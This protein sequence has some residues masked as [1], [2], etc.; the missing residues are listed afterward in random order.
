MSET[1]QPWAGTPLNRRQFL[2]R[3]LAAGSALAMPCIIPA[4]ALGRGGAVA[5]SERIVMGAIG[6]G[7][8]GSNDLAFL[9]GEADVQFVAVCDVQQARREGARNMVNGRY[10]NQ[11][12]VA[13]RDMR[14]LLSAR[15]DIDAMLIATGD[16]WHTP[17]AILAMQA[18]KDVYCEK[19]GALTIAQG[20]ALVAAEKRYG[21]I[22]QTGAQRASE[23]NFI[24]AGE[25]LRQ[26]RLGKIHTVYAHLGYLPDW[27]R[28][29]AVLPAQPEPP[30]EQFDWDLW[31]GPSPWRPYHPAFVN[32]WP[33]PGWYTQ[34][35]FAGGIPQ[36]G[37]HTILQ[38]QLDLG[39]ADTSPVAYEYP[40]DLKG[41]GM[42]VHFANGIKL[43]ARCGGWRGSCGV[44]YEG[45]EG[46]VATADGYGRPEVSSPQLLSDYQKLVQDY[47][48]RTQRPLNHLRNFLNCVR[49]R[50]T[51]VTSAVVAHRTMTTNLLMDICLDL[52][53]DLKWDPVREE[54][55]G[56][57]E[58]N[59]LRSRALRSPWLVG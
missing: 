52:K 30:K 40:A 50:R 32:N 27:P 39:L 55:V 46:W 4:A 47:T 9:L 54:F 19:P 17:A 18:G 36:W 20:Q 25:L 2:K 24:V 6:V 49:T 58:A 53:R 15:T 44:K 29:N 1:R 59:R 51:T 41:A 14:D 23:P 8:Q 26:G 5:P 22:F 48:A 35:D 3:T 16:R 10:G 56:D 57:P 7:G 12:C 34:Y 43:V 21:R 42:T 28:V 37:S 11:D 31:L 33:A 38:C 13:Y 45:T